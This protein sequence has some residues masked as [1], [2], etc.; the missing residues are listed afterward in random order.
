MNT[1]RL[2][3]FAKGIIARLWPH[4]HESEYLREILRNTIR[5]GRLWLRITGRS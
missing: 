5:D 2:S 4:R 1:T 3:P